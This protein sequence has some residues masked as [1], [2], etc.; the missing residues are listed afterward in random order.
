MVH[1]LGLSF[2]FHDSA[3]ALIRDG[4]I[5]AAAQQE[6]F[7][8]KKNDARF[9]SDAISFCLNQA[10]ITAKQL[11]LVAYH[12]EPLTKFNRIVSMA[13]AGF[14]QTM[15]YLDDVVARWHRDRLFD[16][17]E[18]TAQNLGLDPS[19]VVDTRHHISHAA[20]AFFC[21]PF[22]QAAVITIDGVGE[23]ETGGIFKGE[24]NTLTQ[25]SSLELPH[26][27]GLFYS[28]FTAYLGFP[29]NEGE[30]K[31]MGM[32]AFGKPIWK[33]KLLQ[34]FNLLPDGR[35]TLDQGLF[36]FTTP[37][38]IPYTTVM[39]E[40]FGPA[41]K[42]GA[43]F[44]IN[45]ETMPDG[46]TADQR[47]GIIEQSLHY[48]DIAASVQACTEEVILHIV[49]KASASLGCKQ[50]CLAG[51]VGL[52][53]LANG[54]LLREADLEL[55]IQPAAGDAGCALGAAAF[56]WHHTLGGT[57]MA[58]MSTAALGRSFA[59][60]QVDEALASSGFQIVFEQ[61]DED[62]WLNAVA[63]LIASGKVIGWFSGRAEWGPRAL[64]H[65][66]ILAN[67]GL[68]G[69]QRKVNEMI[70]FRE[71][72]RPFAPAVPV[73]R[74]AEF[75]EIPDCARRS[76]P[77]DYMLAVHNVRSEWKDKLPAITHADGTAR[78]QTIAADADPV[79]HRLLTKVGERTGIPIILNT[80][81]NL[82]GEPIVDRPSDAIRTFTLSGLDFLC[83]E[84]RI[85]SKNMTS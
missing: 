75:F 26:S 80:S 60:S 2:G 72:F 8:R 77:E 33:D 25:H 54:R 1:V 36:S 40:V 31:V 35:F 32:A 68:A 69:M 81:F 55:F 45:D 70:K 43:P 34:L 44:A 18:Y 12:E 21:S 19:R 79:F 65:R 67:P 20:S 41:R 57:R 58:P 24:G 83:I 39:T 14:P 29:V 50:V 62:A 49:R 84:N 15:H 78:V 76:R 38:D 6:R 66:S 10:G 42:P 48:A 23:Y 3:A 59:R 22:D 46:V 30:Y 82:N 5:V 28:A 63:D 64:G 13:M 11:D 56:H 17:T 47:V 37:E 73:E 85:L 16:P 4:E 71:P 51:G 52:N 27:L 74:A 61:D 7:S 53:S 9:P